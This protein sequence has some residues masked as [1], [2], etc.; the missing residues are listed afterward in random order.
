[1]ELDPCQVQ[2]VEP[3]GTHIVNRAIVNKNSIT[4]IAAATRTTLPQNAG[5][6]RP[7]T[8]RMFIEATRVSHRTYRR[9]CW[10]EL[11]ML[12][13]DALQGVELQRCKFGANT[14][15]FIPIAEMPGR[16]HSLK[17]YPVLT[18]TETHPAG[19]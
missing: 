7:R 10:Y 17:L 1:M 4:Q 12:H 2:H 14:S 9:G 18:P 5:S 15:E 3:A 16:R 19:W 6:N 13:A 8:L 11:I